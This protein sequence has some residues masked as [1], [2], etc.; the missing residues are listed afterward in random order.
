[1]SVVASGGF[2]ALGLVANELDL[3]GTDAND[4]PMMGFHKHF[5]ATWR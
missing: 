3:L 4:M 2:S 5:C 1:M